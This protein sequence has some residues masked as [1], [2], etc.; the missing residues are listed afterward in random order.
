MLLT[1]QA[2]INVVT[3]I[4]KR[5]LFLGLFLNFV[6]LLLPHTVH[7]D[8]VNL[9]GAETSPNIAE[10]YVL[11][12]QVK[13]KLEIYIGDLEKFDEL[14]PD[15][16]IQDPNIKRASLEQRIQTFATERFRFITEDGTKL[17]AT[18]TKNSGKARRNL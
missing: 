13:V 1:V 12:D 9:T 11:D 16:W 2:Q 14:I 4:R 10:I 18:K 3:F 17:P 7:A 15:E 6:L 5:F 8:W